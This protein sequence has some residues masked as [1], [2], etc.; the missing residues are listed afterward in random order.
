MTVF[1]PLDLNAL[2]AAGLVGPVDAN[3]TRRVHKR[4]LN[5]SS[6]EENADVPLV[7]ISSPE[8]GKAFVDIPN[9]LISLATLRYIGCD[10]DFA[11][12]LWEEWTSWPPDDI[13]RETDDI[14][15]GMP[16]IDFVSGHIEGRHID[17]VDEDDQEWRRCMDACG[18]AKEFQD[19]IMDP[20]FKP[21]RGTESCVF[22]IVETMRM[23]YRGLE[24]IQTASREREMALRRASTRPLGSASAFVGQGDSL[25]RSGH[26]TTHSGNTGGRRSISSTQR[27]AP[28][29]EKNTALSPEAL[30]AM[31]APG[32][33]IVYKGVDQA[34]I[35]GL[36][37]SDGKVIDLQPLISSAPSDFHRS[38]NAF[39]FTISREIAIYYANYAKRRNKIDSVVIVQ[40]AIPNSA[41]ES[42]SE[43][44]CLRVY[45]PSAEWKNLVFHCRKGRRL[46]SELRKFRQATLVIGTIANKPKKVYQKLDSAEHITEQMVLRTRDGRQ[47]VQYV[48]SAEDG[49]QFLEEHGVQELKVFPLTAREHEEWYEHELLGGT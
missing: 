20:V 2:A 16:F 17:A 33:I 43:T 44:E 29:I 32:Y 41:I 6:D 24:E 8:A 15:R 13:L 19:A 37:D 18:V 42:L 5:R 36:Y 38:E 48:W 27:L 40:M 21:I 45:W 49:E 9:D 30:S 34:R 47:A 4:R 46:P 28:G 25:Q 10:D 14:I 31:N 22:W 3:G 1:A 35:N 39:Y 12:Q 11:T 7:P 23:R 26:H